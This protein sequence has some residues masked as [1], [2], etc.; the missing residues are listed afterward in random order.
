MNFQPYTPGGSPYFPQYYPHPQMGQ[1][2][3][4]GNH[5]AAVILVQTAPSYRQFRMQ[6]IPITFTEEDNT[7]EKLME[8]GVFTPQGDLK[9]RALREQKLPFLEGDS[10]TA[11]KDFLTGAVIVSDDLFLERKDTLNELLKFIFGEMGGDKL[12]AAIEEI[13]IAGEGLLKLLQRSNY[14][15]QSLTNHGIHTGKFNLQK[16]LE[17]TFGSKAGFEVRVYLHSPD[18]K[19]LLLLRNALSSYIGRTNNWPSTG[20]FNF[21]PQ[22]EIKTEGD[23][24]SPDAYFKVPFKTPEGDDVVLKV[25]E[26]IRREKIVILGS[27][28]SNG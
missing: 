3:I 5:Q 24:E 14:V 27:F 23:E 15:V 20:L 13:E 8:V 4:P 17:E 25:I 6:R 9:H 16:K 26:K 21:A 18:E 1:F 19:I 22:F 11:I 12:N 10:F 2:P 7:F 28:Y